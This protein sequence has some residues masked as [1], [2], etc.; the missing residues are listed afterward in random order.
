MKKVLI[1]LLVIVALGVAGFAGWLYNGKGKIETAITETIKSYNGS[2]ESVTFDM[3]SDTLT[4]TKLKGTSANDPS[5]TYSVDEIVFVSPN[6][7]S[8]NPATQG[9]PL[10]AKDTTVK[11]VVLNYALHGVKSEVKIAQAR[12]Q[13]WKQNIGK[14]LQSNAKYLSAEYFALAMDAY[15][16]HC[17][18][19]DLQTTTDKP[20]QVVL[21]KKY[22]IKDYT[23]QSV[24][25]YEVIGLQAT[26]K[27]ETVG[28]VTTAI[29]SFT[30]GKMELPP[31]NVLAFFTE[32]AVKDNPTA[33]DGE[34]V[35]KSFM[36]YVG[37]GAQIDLNAKGFVVNVLHA[38]KDIPGVNVGEIQIKGKY[39]PTTAK[40]LDLTFA[41]KDS[42]VNVSQLDTSP[43]G[44]ML[45]KGLLD[46]GM[47]HINKT[48]TTSIRLDNKDSKLALDFSVQKL[49]D[50][51]SSIDFTLPYTSF[52]EAFKADFFGAMQKVMVKGVNV[53]YADMGLLPRS[54]LML[55]DQM[56][57]TPEQANSFINQNIENESAA[58]LHFTSQANVD[59]IKNCILN[60]GTLEAKLVLPE[61]V[62]LM[63]FAGVVMQQAKNLPLELVCKP[64]KPLLE[65]AKGIT[66][67]K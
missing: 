29:D 59:A 57:G 21:I 24:G 6:F 14:L 18:F 67:E 52:D 11:N 39:D 1:A 35:L 56:K 47:A 8:L 15:M 36:E 20:E 42:K 19:V 46:G 30:L 26:T 31:A 50:L 23:P 27:D 33:A 48:F 55:V 37:D 45:H 53:S 66:P 58:L 61:T 44:V 32:L 28:T 64:G 40:S 4:I 49:G 7:D 51:K 12:G 13:E 62:S 38:G 65:A 25:G 17:E 34:K 54:F 2:V 60:P 43:T 9:H 5:L 63:Q 22:I 41:V 3:F 16:P 10:V